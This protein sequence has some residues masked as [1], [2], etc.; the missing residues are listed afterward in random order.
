LQ[1]VAVVGS[2][3]SGKTALIKGLLGDLS[4]VPVAVIDPSI[5]PGTDPSA[6]TLGILQNL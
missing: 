3:G 5:G 4:P 2:V 1:I 6:N